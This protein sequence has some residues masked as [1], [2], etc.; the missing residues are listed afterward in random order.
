MTDMI[1][2]FLKATGEYFSLLRNAQTEYNNVTNELILSYISDF[3]E[4]TPISAHLKDLCSDK[5][6]LTTTLTASHN[7]HLQ[8]SIENLKTVKI[9]LINKMTYKCMPM[10]TDNK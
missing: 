2:S 9:K 1:N 6:I 4:Q 3:E 8:A 10:I 5:N 7:L